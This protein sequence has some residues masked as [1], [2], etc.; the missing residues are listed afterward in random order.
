M[1]TDEDSVYRR[2]EA[3]RPRKARKIFFTLI[4]SVVW[5]GSRSTFVLYTALLTAEY[6]EGDIG[7]SWKVNN[8]LKHNLHDKWLATWM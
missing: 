1:A 4:F 7:L 5:I 8:V 3:I 6:A 2:V